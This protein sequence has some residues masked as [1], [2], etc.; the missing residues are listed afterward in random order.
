MPVMAEVKTQAVA[1]VTSPQ[2]GE[3]L[4]RDAWPGVTSNPAAAKTAHK[5]YQSGPL[6][7]VLAPI[8]WLILSPFLLKR[9]AGA[10]PGLSGLMKRYRLTN[11]RLMVCKGVKS[12]PIQ[13]VGL[14]RIKDVRLKTNETGDYFFGG[15]L[16]VIGENGQVLLEMPGVREAESFS[17]AIRHAAAAWG[18]LLSSKK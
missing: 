15:D 13:E 3:A 10:L 6:R 2:V 9:L 1:G 7:Y 16:E 17:H 18:P 5:F 14:E 4:I 8:G 11:R 12:E